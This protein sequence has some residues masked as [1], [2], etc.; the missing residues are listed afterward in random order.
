MVT[1][2][3]SIALGLPLSVHD[4]QTRR[5]IAPF[6]TLPLLAFTPTHQHGSPHTITFLAAAGGDDVVRDLPKDQPP[7]AASINAELCGDLINLQA[8]IG[9]YVFLYVFVAH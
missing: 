6:K 8:R 1:V 7:C 2:H 5:P 9:W 4:C 3:F